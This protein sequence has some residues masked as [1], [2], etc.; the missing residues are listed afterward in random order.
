MLIKNNV[1]DMW[2]LLP[3]FSVFV[4]AEVALPLFTAK[5]ESILTHSYAS[6]YNE[7]TFPYIVQQHSLFYVMSMVK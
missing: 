3:A 2:K 6:N 4:F 1:L 7:W 5:E